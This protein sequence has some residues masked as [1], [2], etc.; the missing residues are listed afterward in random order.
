M[1]PVKLSSKSLTKA[2]RRGRKRV[3]EGS[4]DWGN[5]LVYIQA[6]TVAG[7]TGEEDTEA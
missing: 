4:A 5:V 1:A 6:T 2:S 3:L 7:G